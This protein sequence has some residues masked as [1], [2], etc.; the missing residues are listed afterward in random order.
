MGA[1]ALIRQT[2]FRGRAL[3]TADFDHLSALVAA[4]NA[5]SEGTKSQIIKITV[6]PT[7]LIDS[8]IAAILRFLSTKHCDGLRPLRRETGLRLGG[9]RRPEF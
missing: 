5:M 2:K 3:A 1:F 6:I 7:A 9:L 4:R 8:H